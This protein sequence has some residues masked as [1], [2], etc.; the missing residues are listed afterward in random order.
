MHSGL[1]SVDT[2]VQY[3]KKNYSYFCEP[4]FVD[5]AAFWPL[6]LSGR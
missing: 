2:N 1:A 6:N 5:I 3:D 4:D